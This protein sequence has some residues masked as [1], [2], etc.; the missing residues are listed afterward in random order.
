MRPLTEPI[1]IVLAGGMGRRIGGC[2]ATVDLC[3]TPLICYPLRALQAAL[4]DVAVIAKPGSLLPSLPGVTV[5]LEPRSPRHPLVGIVHGLGLAEGRAALI[6][7][8][9]LPFVTAAF[10]RRLVETDPDGAPAVLAAHEGA[11]QPLLGCYQPQAAEL[12]APSAL[13]ATV[14]LREAVEAIGPRLLEVEDPELLFNVNAPEDV[15]GAASI[16]DHRRRSVQG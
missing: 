10:V 5:W 15:L 7:A 4:D 2:K 3:G 13:Q 9:D 1:G 16:I 6:C 14:P 8:V 11:P 12:L